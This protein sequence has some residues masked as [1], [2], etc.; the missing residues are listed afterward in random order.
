ML[1]RSHATRSASTRFPR[2]VLGARSWA[3]L[4]AAA[5]G[6]EPRQAWSPGRRTRGGRVESAVRCRSA[7]TTLHRCDRAPRSV[8]R[9]SEDVLPG[10]QAQHSQ[11]T[12]QYSPLIPL[13]KLIS[14]TDSH[15][16]CTDF[17][18]AQ[19]NDRT[20]I[21]LPSQWRPTLRQKI[22]VNIMC[23]SVTIC[24]KSFVLAAESAFQYGG[25][26]PPVR[27]FGRE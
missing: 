27:Q 21:I 22:S 12:I 6:Q 13:Q 19:P 14:V 25:V 11:F 20:Q 26:S 5:T 4:R 2:L 8:R 17:R 16:F 24:G 7:P 3:P 23:L 18:Q 9:H 15:R 1:G 10:H